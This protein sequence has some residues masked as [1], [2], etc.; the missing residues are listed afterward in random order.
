M[1]PILS[2]Y[3]SGP[4]A[5]YGKGV[6]LHTE[7]TSL[8]LDEQM[9]N[10][11]LRHEISTFSQR[12]GVG[13]S[14]SQASVWHMHYTLQIL[15]SIIVAQSV[16][17]QSLPLSL[18]DV[19]W[20]TKL[21]QLQLPNQG[22]NLSGCPTE[23]RYYDLIFKHLAPLHAWLNQ[24]FG[25]S[26]KVL[27]SN[28]TFRINQFLH[29]IEHALGHSEHLKNERRILLNEC[30]INDQTNPLY[31]KPIMLTDSLNTYRIRDHCCL[32]HDVPNKSH[33]SDCPKLPKHIAHY[34]ANRV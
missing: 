29:A 1:L 2:P 20:H 28:C 31:S 9:K 24:Q 26:S 5:N 16:L 10:G 7:H 14:R 12:K 23:I 33:C 13:K 3:L 27:W 25:I 32:L 21:Q 17:Q 4:F 6:G 19:L 15:P 8:T 30:H 22:I 18:K 34:S 11:M